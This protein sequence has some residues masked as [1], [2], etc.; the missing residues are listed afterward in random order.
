MLFSHYQCPQRADV[1]A[2]FLLPAKLDV[3]K[4]S[5]P[6]NAD[7]DDFSELR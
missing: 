7:Y 2:F 3:L 6:W 1:A 4:E 5:V